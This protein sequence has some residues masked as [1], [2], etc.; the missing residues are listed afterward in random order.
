MSM[1]HYIR[2]WA[3]IGHQHAELIQTD[4]R[5][6]SIASHLLEEIHHPGKDHQQDTST[7]T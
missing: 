5:V 6:S 2:I 3:Q 7:R 1:K 4:L